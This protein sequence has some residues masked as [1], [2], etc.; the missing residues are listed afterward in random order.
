MRSSSR[1]P[2][3]SAPPRTG[4]RRPRISNLPAA[5][6]S[7]IGRDTELGD[8]TEL[9]S[10][11]AVRLVTLVG[12]GGTGKTRLALAAAAR[13]EQFFADGV[14]WVSLDS[15]SADDRVLDAVAAALGVPGNA[16]EGLLAATTAFL[17]PRH[18]LLVLDNFEQV[19]DAW[20]LI[21]D[22]LVAAPRLQ[23][24]ITSRVTLHLSGEQRFDV[25]QLGLPPQRAPI[26]ARCIGASEAVQLFV[27]RAAMVD[28]RFRL[29][30]GN[31]GSIASLCHRL[32]GLPLAIELA[33]GHI[34]QHSPAALLDT[35]REQLEVARG[36]PAGRERPAAHAPRLHRV[37]LPTL[38]RP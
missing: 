5:L 27:A 20:P 6:S 35:L 9:L 26:T 29:D 13:T 1:T 31:A 37:E 2:P 22:L 34:S 8:L 18:L 15:V 28:R 7:F 11:G 23:V 21:T 12:P 38:G 19:L 32:D 4:G 17:R 16:S 30:D 36:R 3:C 10:Q 33:A 14:C 24:L 25:T